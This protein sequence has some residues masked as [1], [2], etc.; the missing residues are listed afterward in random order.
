MDASDEKQLLQ[1]L[2]T[3]A[4]EALVPQPMG[5]PLMQALVRKLHEGLASVEQF[6]VQYSQLTPTAPSLRGFGSAGGS[7]G[8]KP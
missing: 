7:A 2:L 8:A 4:E 6:P 1:R 5:N 3:F